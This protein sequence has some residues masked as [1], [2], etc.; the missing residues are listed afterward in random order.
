MGS[1]ESSFVS[2]ALAFDVKKLGLCAAFLPFQHTSP[3][4]SA[5]GALRSFNQ[6]QNSDPSPGW[7]IQTISDDSEPF[8]FGDDVPQVL[9]LSLRG[10]EPV[11]FAGYS[12]ECHDP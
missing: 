11:R 5:A 7:A 12:G 6:L 9:P 3:A 1:W 10:A 2:R 4:A 8:S